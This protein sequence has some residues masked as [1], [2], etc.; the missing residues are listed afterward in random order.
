MKIIVWIKL[1][2][3][4]LHQKK[5]YLSFPAFLECF[6]SIFMYSET[7]H[8]ISSIFSIHFT[9]SKPFHSSGWFLC[10][11]SENRQAFT[12]F[13]VFLYFMHISNLINVIFVHRFFLLKHI[14]Y[15]LFYYRIFFVISFICCHFKGRK[16]GRKREAR[17]EERRPWKRP[18]SSTL[19][20]KVKQQ[21]INPVFQ[22]ET[23]VWQATA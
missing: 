3:T 21:G 11:F 22:S 15:K 5:T 17:S 6:S 19:Q 12:Y 7:C 18:L 14:S 2:K 10:I 4:C 20:E 16:T 9:E 8:F 23:A 13:P 1:C